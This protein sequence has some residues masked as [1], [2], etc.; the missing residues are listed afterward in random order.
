MT[1]CGAE[2]AYEDG[3]YTAPVEIV[4]RRTTLTATDETTGEECRIAVYY[5]PA[6]VKGYRISSDDN[7]L[8]LADIT[9]HKDEY[10]SI[11]E[12]PYLCQQAIESILPLLQ[13]PAAPLEDQT[14]VVLYPA[15][16]VSGNRSNT[17]KDCTS[18]KSRWI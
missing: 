3:Y 7:I 18:K 12:N 11:F 17:H 16:L 5:L 6:S 14:I 8:F 1:I 10:A 9:A 15:E 2:A 4:G 13:G